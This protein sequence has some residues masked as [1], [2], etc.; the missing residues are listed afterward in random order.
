MNLFEN[1]LRI[2]ITNKCN[3]RCFFCHGEGIDSSRQL[4]E[5]INPQLVSNFITA[6]VRD[7]TISGGEPLVALPALIKLLDG[8]KAILPETM[9]KEVTLTIV[10][11]GSL[12]S[13]KIINILMKEYSCF[14][15]LR[16][17]ISLHSQIESV[18]DA[19]TGTKSRHKI[20]ISNIK[21]AIQHG[22]NVSLN[23]VL[24]RNYNE[25]EEEIDS[26]MK[27]SS[28]IGVSRIKLIEFLV[29]DMNR[30]FY[31]SFSRLESVIYNHR[32]RASSI[33][34]TSKRKIR[35]EYP[36][37][38]IKVDYTKC[39]CA[40]GCSEC[41]KSR[42]IEM[43]P[44]GNF[45]GCIVQPALKVKSDE[46]VY[47]IVD[48]I[49]NQLR[50]MEKKYGN[51]SPSLVFTPENVYGSAVFQIRHT[52]KLEKL[53]EIGFVHTHRKYYRFELGR[54]ANSEFKFLLIELD[55]D[56]HSKLVCFKETAKN[57]N[58]FHW[59][60]MDYLDHVYE[61]SRTRAEVNRKKVLAMGLELNDPIT[62]EE[63][64]I[65]LSNITSLYTARL[66]RISENGE[67][68]FLLE[69]LRPSSELWENN[70][71]I[72]FAIRIAQVHDIE[73]L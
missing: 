30:Q 67:T 16:L 18:Y 60:E 12:L 33:E 1:G 73:F 25:K 29:T 56:T 14:K 68:R 45:V 55:E 72:T 62:V 17:N 39:T 27:F 3:Y 59:I 23:Y 48:R 28:S 51:Y 21:N 69:I 36:E 22:L 8:I 65:I 66:K 20:V 70:E 53:F 35:H 34:N 13:E 46:S 5:K 31:S 2:I 7:L 63:D 44:D 52:E 26:I 42:E 58:E 37:Y 38:N 64:S 9:C 43:S 10:T 61:F 19:V 40:L 15:E 32:H 6:G 57:N 49:M 4:N 71:P 50:G 11:N 24:L 41:I 47:K 54:P